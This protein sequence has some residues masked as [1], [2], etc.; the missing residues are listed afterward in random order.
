MANPVRVR[1]KHWCFTYNNPVENPFEFQKVI[2]DSWDTSYAVFQPEYGVTGSP[3]FQGYVEF[4][5]PM[6]LPALKKLPSAF[7][8]HWEK[9]HGKRE[10][11]RDYC[12]KK[13]DARAP[14]P[15]EDES[16][17]EDNS[18]ADD[19]FLTGP[20]EVGVFV[21]GAAQ[22]K[23]TDLHEVSEKVMEGMS[24]SDIASEHPNS[25][26]RYVRGITAL[27][28]TVRKPIAHEDGVLVSLLIGPP[29]CG[30]TRKVRDAEGEH[31]WVSPPGSTMQ[32][33]NGYD[34]HEAVLFDDFDGRM[35]KVP[36]SLVLQYLDRYP[37]HAP[38]KG[39]YC[40]F[41]PKRIYV[42]TNI[43]PCEWYEWGQRLAQ[44]GALKR[45]FSEVHLWGDDPNPDG[46]WDGATVLTPEEPVSWNRFWDRQ[47]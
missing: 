45:R 19:P 13:A 14:K 42:T 23:R 39:S 24:L 9:R 36:L 21:A 31:L 38:T 5:S 3:H 11:A 27:K 44:F 22:G 26:I 30:K 8:I 40:W 18:Q 17:V 12:M 43:H 1:A 41:N 28:D 16:T 33:F 35:S 15:G 7:T 46:D 10:E 29:G 47:Y 32:W 25:F 34:G 6:S 2:E 20:L 37:V 4:N